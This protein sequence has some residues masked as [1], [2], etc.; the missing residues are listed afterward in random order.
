MA[1][2]VQVGSPQ[3]SIHQDQTILTT[4]LDG[5]INGRAK[6]LLKSQVYAP[7]HISGQTHQC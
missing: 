1:F 7:T 2:K 3:I 5:Q 4:D 6:G